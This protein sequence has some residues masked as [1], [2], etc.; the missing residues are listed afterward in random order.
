M[1]TPH[2][3]YVPTEYEQML[4]AADW[5][6]IESLDSEYQEYLQSVKHLQQ[7][8]DEYDPLS[9]I[10]WKSTRE[11]WN[12][13]DAD[14]QAEI[15]PHYDA[16]PDGNIPWQIRERESSLLRQMDWLETCLGY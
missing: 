7:R 9:Y 10:S 5:V 6:S 12:R 1:K 15:Q 3:N 2:A 11:E 13:L 16:R 14:Y 8:F 4:I